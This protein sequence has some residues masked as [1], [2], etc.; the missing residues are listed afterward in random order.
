MDFSNDL[1]AG[2]SHMRDDDPRSLNDDFVRTF[3]VS[4]TPASASS[5]DA[6]S[7]L[8]K[9]EFEITIRR[10]G[11][12]TKF[13]F[14]HSADTIR[15]RGEL[16]V[17]IL[18][19]GGEFVVEQKEHEEV[20]A[21]IAAGV[22]ITPLLP[23]LNDLDLARLRVLWTV[24][25]VDLGLVED[26]L[27]EDKGLGRVVKVFVTSGGEKVEEEGVERSVQKI[28]NLGAELCRRRLTKEDVAEVETAEA[29]RYYL[30]MSVPM[31]KTVEEW[32]GA[33]EVIF[34]DFNF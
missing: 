4:S 2:Y 26:V 8:A 20:V 6:S 22:G 12:V 28:K 23:C 34:E 11:V 5:S 13:L 15:T 30:C 19:F 1:D 7:G 18:G 32:L 24:R 29:A 31:R 3:T 21:F 10:V 16:D 14:A 9:D 17:K 25:E 33:K 27:A